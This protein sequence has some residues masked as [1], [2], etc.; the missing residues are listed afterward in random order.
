MYMQLDT[1]FYNSM[2]AYVERK[3]EENIKNLYSK[4]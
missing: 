3:K 1:V 2:H 4:T